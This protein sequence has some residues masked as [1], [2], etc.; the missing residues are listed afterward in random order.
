MVGPPIV[1]RLLGVRPERP[2]S[3]VRGTFSL[4]TAMCSTEAARKDPRVLGIVVTYGN[5]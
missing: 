3:A 2:P 5:A 1:A 4:S